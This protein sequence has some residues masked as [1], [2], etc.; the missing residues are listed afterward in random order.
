MGGYTLAMQIRYGV[1]KV[2]ESRCLSLSKELAQDLR[3]RP[4]DLG[5]VL[6]FSHARHDVY[7]AGCSDNF[8]SVLGL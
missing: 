6:P 8:M 7:Q 3:S 1:R 2:I 4:G 5:P